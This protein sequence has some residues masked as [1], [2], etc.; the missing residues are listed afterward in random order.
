MLER[1]GEVD[2]FVRHQA[3]AQ[4]LQLRFCVTGVADGAGYLDFGLGHVL[5]PQQVAF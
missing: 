5:P 4:R 2:Q 1:A 3:L